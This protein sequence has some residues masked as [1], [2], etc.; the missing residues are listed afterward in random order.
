MLLN[1]IGGGVDCNQAGGGVGVFGGNPLVQMINSRGGVIASADLDQASAPIP[2]DA[3]QPTTNEL[4]GWTIGLIVLGVIV[5][6]GLVV[7]QVQVCM[8]IRT[9]L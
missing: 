8:F 1:S 9:S 7:V 6:I 5:L 2:A 4:P 3:A